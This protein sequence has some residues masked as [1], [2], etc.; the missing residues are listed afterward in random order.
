MNLLLLD[1]EKAFDRVYHQKLIESL[2][3]MRIPETV[4]QIKENLYSN[5]TFEVEINSTKSDKKT[6]QRGIRQGCPYRRTC[7]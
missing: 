1:L 3:R 5:P 2:N 7:S 6:Q 4:V